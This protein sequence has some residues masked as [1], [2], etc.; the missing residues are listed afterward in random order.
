[1]RL[2]LL[3]GGVGNYRNSMSALKPLN[4]TEKSFDR[5]VSVHHI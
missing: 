5:P 3:F 2:P 1:M 4:M